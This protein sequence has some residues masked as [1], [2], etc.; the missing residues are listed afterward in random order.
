MEQTC[1]SLV[2]VQMPHHFGELPKKSILNFL[3]SIWSILRVNDN[4]LTNVSPELKYSTR[5]LAEHLVFYLNARKMCEGDKARD[6]EGHGIVS[7][8]P[9]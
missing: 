3:Y 2:Y 4:S 6:G 9:I 5:K 1:F 8:F 7:F